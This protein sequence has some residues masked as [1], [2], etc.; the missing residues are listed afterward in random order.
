V[1]RRTWIVGAAAVAGALGFLLAVV[2]RDT[3]SA[4]TDPAMAEWDPGATPPA[5]AQQSARRLV[6]PDP[7]ERRAAVTPE[8][9]ETLEQGEQ[10]PE[11]ADVVLDVDGWREHGGY[12]VATG[13]LVVPGQSAE[14]IVVGF[15]DISGQWLVAFEES[16]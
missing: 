13:V 2:L 8:L 4:G 12:A 7:A 16:T 6:S 5:A 15:V 1:S 3:P 10:V 14:R 11:H 9:N